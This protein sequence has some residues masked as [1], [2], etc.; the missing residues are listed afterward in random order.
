MQ[1]TESLINRFLS[2]QACTQEEIELVVRYLSEHPDR[3][4]DYLERDWSD[5][6]D[7]TPISPDETA[8][9][10][11]KIN[12]LAFGRTRRTGISRRYV[13]GWTAA[14]GV[15]LIAGILLLRT[16]G[17]NVSQGVAAVKIN[18]PQ[19]APA[20]NNWQVKA[21]A[22]STREKVTLPD[23]STV[24]L[25]AQSRIHYRDSF[26]GGER[27]VFLEGQAT[28][29]VVH[30]AAGGMHGNVPFRVRAGKVTTTVLG[31]S[32]NILQNEKGV[33]VKLYNGKVSVLAAKKDF[34]LTPGQQVKYNAGMDV[35]EVTP[36]REEAID[37]TAGMNGAAPDNKETLVF[38]NTPLPKVME[39]L[40]SRYHVPI[41]YDSRAIGKM[42]FTGSVLG[43]DSLATILH[44]IANMNDLKVSRQ[45]NGFIVYASDK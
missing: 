43:S 17:T 29:D 3:L 26:A 14:A 1:I 6:K 5:A 33:I 45:G 36:F 22:G 19:Q 16:S 27:E 18:A 12:G 7:G 32:F 20:T 21:N 10:L 11:E 28:F 31:T 24:F 9:M 23:G 39:K 8:T 44:V 4:N 13:I 41:Q 30:Q 40:I 42:D 34:I 2:G 38:N 25:F 35:A 15:I 37:R